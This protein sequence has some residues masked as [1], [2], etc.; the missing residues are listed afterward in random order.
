MTHVYMKDA[1]SPTV[2]EMGT[3]GS[4]LHKVFSH[5]IPHEG[6]DEEENTFPHHHTNCP[7][8]GQFGGVA[9]G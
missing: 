9:D 5:P 3:V 2:H 8:L 7:W 1:L 6:L 4:V